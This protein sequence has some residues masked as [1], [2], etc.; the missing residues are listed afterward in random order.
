MMFGTSRS[1]R[2][3]ARTAPTDLRKGY[4]GLYGLVKNELGRDPLSGDL[5]LF[6]NRQRTSCKVLMWDGT[7]LCI[8]MK[9]LERGRFALL[10]RDPERVIEG[11]RYSLDFAIKVAVDKH[12]DHLPLT[13]QARIMGRHGL[14]VGS[15]TLWDQLEALARQLDAAWRELFVQLMH[16]PVIGLDQTSWK[17]LSGAKKTPWQMWCVTGRRGV[18]HQICDDKS[19]ATFTALVGRY[20]GVIVCDA[21]ATHGAGARAS[22]LIVLAGCWAHVLRKFRDAVP[23]HP[24]AHLALGWSDEL[25]DIDARAEG[26][27]DALAELRRTESVAVLAKLKT[28][29][30]SQAALKSLSIGKAAAY[31]I[32]NWD[33][34]RLFVTDP[35]IPLDNNATERG[36]RGPVVGRKNHYGSKSRRGTEVASI[37]YSLIETAKLHGVDPA[38]YLREAALAHKRGETLLPWQLAV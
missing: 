21:A 3:W 1:E 37:F 5:H 8:F 18:Y 2:V 22:P 4:N 20:E 32:A 28:W 15:Q 19:E 14:E 17:R 34:L 35:R 6:V 24:E 38:T 23:D 29:L 27:L 36:I 16:E 31:V 10:R 7:G 9:R 13:R 30:W 11:G 12:L 33:R 25:Y 26:D